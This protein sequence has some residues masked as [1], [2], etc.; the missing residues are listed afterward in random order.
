[1]ERYCLNQEHD[2]VLLRLWMEFNETHGD[3]SSYSH[4]LWRDQYVIN[5]FRSQF[6]GFDADRYNVFIPMRARYV[7][8]QHLRRQRRQQQC[9]RQN[10]GSCSFL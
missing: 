4:E 1:M 6:Q 5:R 2:A 8:E 10:Q 9:Q 7:H 3:G